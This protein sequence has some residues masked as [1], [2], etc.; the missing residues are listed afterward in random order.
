MIGST[1]GELAK[2][3]FSDFQGKS[4]Y[5][6]LQISGV[7]NSRDHRLETTPPDD[8]IYSV[9]QPR[10]RPVVRFVLVISQQPQ[11]QLQ[12]REGPVF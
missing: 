2:L 5:G 11:N 3:S 6:H 7:P 12:N 4:N 1:I 10:C 8:T 9:S